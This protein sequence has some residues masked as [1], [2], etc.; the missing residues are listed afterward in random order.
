MNNIKQQFWTYS[1]SCS[2]LLFL[3]LNR[4]ARL[5]LISFLRDGRVIVW[6]AMNEQ[7]SQ[8]GNAEVA[9]VGKQYF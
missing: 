7:S 1:V 9:N 3:F 4:A 8:Q 2:K 5:D 6:V